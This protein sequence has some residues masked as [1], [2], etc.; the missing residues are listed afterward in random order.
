MMEAHSDVWKKTMLPKRVLRRRCLRPRHCHH[1]RMH[2]MKLFKRLL[3]A[4]RGKQAVVSATKHSRRVSDRKGVC[5]D[6]REEL[7]DKRERRLR[8]TQ[9]K[10]HAAIS[11]M[12]RLDLREARLLLG[13]S[14]QQDKENAL[15]ER[16]DQVEQIDQLESKIRIYET[17]NSEEEIEA[18]K[19]R[20]VTDSTTVD[21]QTRLIESLQPEI[22][23]LK[24][25]RIDDAGM[26]EG[27]I[28]QIGK[29]R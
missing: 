13:E 15:R 26:V 24:Q 18:L 25:A 11:K 14:D 6:V 12:A 21:D 7:L 2:F 29:L 23:G 8:K 1:R 9:S 16:V 19:R 5:L 10:Y 20:V 27:W 4:S 22:E 3:Y 17:G 28:R